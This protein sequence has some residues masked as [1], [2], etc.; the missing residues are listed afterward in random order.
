MYFHMI[1]SSVDLSHVASSD[2]NIMK[3]RSKETKDDFRS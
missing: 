3:D 2:F 1:E